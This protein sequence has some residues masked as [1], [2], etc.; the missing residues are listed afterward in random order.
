MSSTLAEFRDLCAELS[1]LANQLGEVSAGGEVPG[2]SVPP[3]VDRILGEIEHRWRAL[4][5]GIDPDGDPDVPPFGE[6]EPSW[7][8]V[9]LPG[10]GG[11]AIEILGCALPPGPGRKILT[12]AVALALCATNG[13]AALERLYRGDICWLVKAALDAAGDSLVE[14]FGFLTRLCRLTHYHGGTVDTWNNLHFLP[15]EAFECVE[16][17]LAPPHFGFGELWVEDEDHERLAPADFGFAGEE[18]ARWGDL[19]SGR[20]PFIDIKR[21][22]RRYGRW[23]DVEDAARCALV[24]AA[25]REKRFDLGDNSRDDAEG[26]L[27]L[28]A[29]LRPGASSSGDPAIRSFVEAAILTPKTPKHAAAIV[30]YLAPIAVPSPRERIEWLLKQLKY[31]PRRPAVPSFKDDGRPAP[32]W[33]PRRSERLHIQEHVAGWTPWLREPDREDLGEVFGRWYAEAAASASEFE[34]VMRALALERDAHQQLVLAERGVVPFELYNETWEKYRRA[35]NPDH[36]AP[37]EP[38]PKEVERLLAV[39]DRIDRPAPHASDEP[40]EE[41]D[42]LVVEEEDVGRQ[43]YEEFVDADYEWP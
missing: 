5:S 16:R 20:F 11:D 3:E 8:M 33:P 43:P 42:D 6:D 38:V 25:I 36:A 14:R 15:K 1:A 4:R 21:A 26:A 27:R 13:E 32:P 19:A 2:A 28:F 10:E 39:L 40:D 30:R 37:S 12:H 29:E 35:S 34:R 23:E 24:R 41:D 7:E 18:E 9:E 31:L 22:L 17:A